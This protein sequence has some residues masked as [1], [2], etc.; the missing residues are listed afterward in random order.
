MAIDPSIAL[1]VKTLEL[2][3]QLAQYGQIAAIQNAQNQNALAQYQIES[4]KR[5][6][7][8]KNA[9][10]LAYKDA[11]DPT[12]GSIDPS[13]LRQ[14][15]ASGGF[16]A[17]L[18]TV[19]K[20]L[21]EI[22]KLKTETQK[23]ETDL[24]DSKLK[25]SR[26]FLD[27]IDPTDPKAPAQYIAWHEANHKDPV[28]GPVL[29]ARGVT[30]DQARGRIM[31]AINKG[32]AAFATLLN[33]SK[34]GTDRFMELNK[35]TTT[36]V[37]RNG[38]TDIVSQPGLG[39]APTTLATYADVPLPPAVFAQQLQKSAA[40]AA[41]SF[42]NVNAQ[43]PASEEAQKEFMKEF[44]ATY[45]ALKQAPVVLENIEAA[46]KLIPQAKGFMGA[47]GEGMLQAASFLNNRLGTN[48]DTKGVTNAEELRSRLFMGVLDNLKK[49]DS[50]PSQ[51]QQAALQKALGSIGTDPN[52]LSNVLDVFG[53]AVRRKV[54]L[55]NQEATDA[56]A[57]GV[58]FPYNPKIAL[59]GAPANNAG[60]K[61]NIPLEAIQKLKAGQGTDAQ[62][63]AIFGAGA[64]KRAR[65]Q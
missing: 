51:Q 25:Q 41:R 48:I 59:P 54:E 1:G 24:I 8:T 52:A 37:N 33:Q 4:A 2:P 3:N 61:L 32:P 5:A 36:T 53:G 21:L 44:R 49:L 43:L 23:A 30:A 64:A 40:G 47:G 56:E 26:G 34:L 38:Q 35:P 63:D 18:P 7:A 46:K 60:G 28:L 15:L 27:T 55:H 62:F 17:E 57:R 29:A 6:D 9:L 13:K 42:T 22:G 10:S 16:G 19:E 39:G 31:D 58:K 45:G 65:G 11:Y 20:G 12:T 14:S 50:Q